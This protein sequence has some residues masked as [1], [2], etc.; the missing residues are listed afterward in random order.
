[1]ELKELY[2][3]KGQLVT[4]HEQISAKLQQINGEILKAMQQQQQRP[5]KPNINKS[6][7]PKEIKKV[8]SKYGGKNAEKVKEKLKKLE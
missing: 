6:M 8:V 1:M 5:Q 3:I 4:Q 2:A 7:K